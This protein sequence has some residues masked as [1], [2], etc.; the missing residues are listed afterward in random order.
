MD[1]ANEQDMVWLRL[2]IRY[3]SLCVPVLVSNTEHTVISCF[4]NCTIMLMRVKWSRLTPSATS[5]WPRLRVNYIRHELGEQ[6]VQGVAPG[7]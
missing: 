1:I 6:R 7:R 2:A 3:N 4:K 5:L